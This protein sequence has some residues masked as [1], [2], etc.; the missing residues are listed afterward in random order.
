MISANFGK[1]IV[2]A[3]AYD[4]RVGGSHAE[5]RIHLTPRKKVAADARQGHRQLS[6]DGSSLPAEPHG[7]GSALV[8]FAVASKH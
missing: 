5:L 7:R 8:E 3:V 4:E 1:R 2:D 6:C